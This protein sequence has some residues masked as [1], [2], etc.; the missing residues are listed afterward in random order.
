MCEVW[1]PLIHHARWSGLVKTSEDGCTTLDNGYTE[2]MLPETRVYSVD[3]R[4][5]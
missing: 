1:G 3:V 4:N 2:C 5:P